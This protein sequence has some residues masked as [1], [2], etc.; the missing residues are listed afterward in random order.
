MQLAYRGI[1]RAI[2]NLGYSYRR[3]RGN[4]PSLSDI[5]QVD[6][7]TYFPINTE[8]SLFLRSLYDLEENERI[9]DLAGIEYNS[10]CWRIRLV[11][12]RSLDQKT[13]ANV[14]ELVE[15]ENAAF[16][17]FQLKGLGGVGTRVSSMLEEVIRGY[18][19]SDE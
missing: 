4:D 17:E 16:V 9:N 15:H 8:W 7:S 3:Y 1:N 2:F 12:Q 14:S 5:E 18:K 11:Y 10:C 6:F 13:G 19:A